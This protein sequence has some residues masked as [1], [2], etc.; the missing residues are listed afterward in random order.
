LVTRGAVVPIV[1][2]ALPWRP[3]AAASAAAAG[4]L[5]VAA[6]WPTS[7]FATIGIKLALVCLAAAACFVLDE[8]AAAVVDSA[9]KTLRA[10]TVIRLSGVAIPATIG[11]A[12]L[13]A[14]AARLGPA[15]YG[16]GPFGELPVGGL[17]LQLAGCLLL[18]VAT[19][20]FARRFMPEPGD[21]VSGMVAGCL[22][23]LVIYNPFGRWVD[24]FPISPQDRWSRSVVLWTIV[25]LL[26][27]VTVARATRDPLD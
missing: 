3:L 7:G 21:Y 15:P 5:G 18:G 8:P 10:R 9:P 27:L 4:M 16:Q 12:G 1:L 11:A 20:A 17:L 13:V 6:I 22:T 2:T 26:S 23:T 24:V 14:I 19:A 25:C